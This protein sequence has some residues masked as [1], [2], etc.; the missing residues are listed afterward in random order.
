M[1]GL[2]SRLIQKFVIIV[3]AK[4]LD[5]GQFMCSRPVRN[6]DFGMFGYF[7]FGKNQRRK[8][9]GKK[10]KPTSNLPSPAV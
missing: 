6:Q 5:L 7:I 3:S 8:I 9:K 2:K 4:T 10:I 1:A